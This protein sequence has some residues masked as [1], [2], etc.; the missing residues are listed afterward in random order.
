MS[1]EIEGAGLIV[2]AVALPVAAAFGAGWLAWQAGKLLVE[3]N[4]AVDRDIQEKQRQLQEAE[5]Q[6]KL[7][8]QAGRRQLQAMCASVLAELDATGGN[9]VEV[10]A[11]RQELRQISGSLLPEDAVGIEDRNLADLARLERIVNCQKRLQD[12]KIFGSGIYDGL[13]VA[14]L[15]DDLRLAVAAAKIAETRGKDVKVAD[16]AVLERV[17]LNHRLSE[18]STQV[19][20]A[21]EFV[22]DLAE[23]Y[24]V[25]QA[26][27]AWF[28]SCFNGVDER[29]RDLCSPSVSNANLKKGIRS[30]EEIMSQYEMLYPSLEQE[31]RQLAALYPIYTDAARALGE[32]VHRLKHFKSAAALETALQGLKTRA[33]RARTCAE[34]YQKL[35]PAAYMCYAWDEELR[36]MGY[37]VHT[38]RQILEMTRCRPERAKLGEAEMPFYQWNQGAVTQLYHI[39]P[40]C[41]LQLIVHPDGSTTMQTIASQQAAHPEQVV[42]TQKA[43]CAHVKAIHQRLKENWFI[44]YDYQE[45]APAESLFSTEAWLGFQDNAWAKLD[46]KNQEAS[47]EAVGVRENARHENQKVMRKQ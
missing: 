29:I 35:G 7:T 13:S 19:M 15:M 45:S 34:I 22:V 31:K 38:R 2:A 9:A 39:T 26:N 6:R 47:T 14:D 28:Q 44:F 21:L 18:V 41:N 46:A 11:M 36:A 27:N 32:P 23:N 17:K 30:L 37:T 10:E 12:V 3:A 40:E 43:H 25:S 20:T 42:E 8:A 33:Q 24:G 16:P 5:K 1:S 4:E